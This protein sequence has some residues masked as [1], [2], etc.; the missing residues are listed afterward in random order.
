METAM[1]KVQTL[2]M[3]MEMWNDYWV[4]EEGLGVSAVL[5]SLVA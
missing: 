1:L 3:A 4:A 5:T 2:K